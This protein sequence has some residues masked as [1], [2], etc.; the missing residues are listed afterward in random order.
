MIL[1]ELFAD[2]LVGPLPT[3]SMSKE[4]DRRTPGKGVTR[5]DRIIVN[6]EAA[7]MIRSFEVLDEVLLPG[8]NP[9][10]IT[11]SCDPVTYTIHSLAVPK[12]FVL[13][14]ADRVTEDDKKTSGHCSSR[15]QKSS[16]L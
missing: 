7:S 6:Q 3:Y 14:R 8:H 12:P 16:L 10:R 9:I 1:G 5:P 15:Q 13:D 11:F 2:R 4:W